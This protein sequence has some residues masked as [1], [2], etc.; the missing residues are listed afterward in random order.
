MTPGAYEVDVRDVE[1]FRHGDE[2][3]LARL[4][5]PR[6]SGPFPL[7]LEV[8]GG[9]WTSGDRTSDETINQ[10]ISESGVVV[11]AI[12]F[13]QPPDAIYPASLQDVHVAIRWVKANAAALN[14][15]PDLIGAL[16]TSSGGHQVMLTALQPHEPSYAALPLPGPLERDATLDFVVLCWPIVDPLARYRWARRAGKTNLVEKHDAY[17]GTEDAMAAG[18]PQRIV[19]RLERHA[20]RFPAA[21]VIQGTG[22]DNIPYSMVEHFVD[23]YRRAG[24]NIHLELFDGEPHGFIKQQPDSHPAARALECIRVFVR[25]QADAR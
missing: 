5:Q 20:F 9:V 11:V 24:G 15:R 6:A 2:P 22:D 17:W 8:H 21:L 12:D 7:L 14:G 25:A 18:S 10:T 23:V 13:R 3:L 16:G 19:E 4:Y 1:Y